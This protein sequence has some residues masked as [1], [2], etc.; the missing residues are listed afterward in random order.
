M[1]RYPHLICTAIVL[2]LCGATALGDS[3]ID[4]DRHILAYDTPGQAIN[5]YVTLPTGQGNGH[6]VQG[7]AFYAQIDDGLMDPGEMIPMISD[8]N[9]GDAGMIFAP[10]N[11][12]GIKDPEEKV[13]PFGTEDGNEDEPQIY[14]D[15]FPLIELRD[16]S[17][18]DPGTVEAIGLLGT[19]IVD[20]TGVTQEG[21][22]PLLMAGTLNGSSVLGYHPAYAQALVKNVLLWAANGG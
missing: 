8:I 19:I 6:Q 10:P 13:P 11:N 16:T 14:P 9:I 12:T 4:V 2:S 17:T 5:I 22:W 7:V 18:P 21:E 20:T 3:I 15:D 1:R